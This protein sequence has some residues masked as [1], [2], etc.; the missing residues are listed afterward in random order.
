MSIKKTVCLLIA[1]TLL[2]SGSAA[3]DTK[4]ENNEIKNTNIL[5]YDG[6]VTDYKIVIP[7][8]AREAETLAAEEAAYFLKSSSGA[9]F[10]IITDKGKSFNKSEKVISIGNTSVLDGS[11]LKIDKT[12]LGDSGFVIK[13]FDNTVII[14]GAKEGYGNGNIYG[15]YDFLQYEIDYDYYCETEIKYSGAT[16]GYVKDFDYTYVPTFNQRS[17]TEFALETDFVYR[18]RMRLSSPNTDEFGMWGH[19]NDLYI[20]PHSV[21]GEE[22]PDWY[23]QPGN[24]GTDTRWQLC[25]TNEEMRVEYVRRVKE[26]IDSKPD[27]KY[28]M[29]GQQDVNTYCKCDNCTKALEKYKQMSGV[30]IVFANKVVDEI[31]PWFNEKYP[32]REIMFALFAYEFTETP[33]LTSDGN[34][35][36][37][38]T[39]EDCIPRDNIAILIAPIKVDWS[40]PLDG[41]VNQSSYNNIKQWS[42]VANHLLIWK[43]S[44][45]ADDTVFVPFNNLNA[46]KT[47]NDSLRDCNLIYMLE[48]AD[49]QVPTA[50]FEELRIYVQSNLMWN[51][52]QTAESLIRKFIDGYYGEASDE[53]YEYYTLLNTWQE[54]VRKNYNACNGDVWDT[55]SGKA[56]YWPHEMLMRFDEALDRAEEK[57]LPLKSP[58]NAAYAKLH[59]RI[60]KERMLNLYFRLTFHRAYYNNGELAEMINRFERITSANKITYIGTSS[61]AQSCSDYIKELRSKLI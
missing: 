51:G 12:V 27:S 18:N 60:E 8:N 57:I 28:F 55:P 22:H 32:G 44:F 25:F 41:G 30:Q 48:E 39:H 5:L 1:A 21:Y 13:R 34:G 14:A 9:E 2:L 43:Y 42:L 56:D 26:I 59:A 20:L 16:T 19:S 3:C 40:E 24:A 46:Y 29:L 37:R 33:P 17:I 45:Y 31:M 4:Q 7:E 38:V 47:I 50:S 11:G 54:T 53:M 61:K 23:S 10:E 52:N 36:Y 49:S 15:V 35:G 58:D 6:G